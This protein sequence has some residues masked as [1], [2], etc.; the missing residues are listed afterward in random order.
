M[1]G[2]NSFELALLTL[3]VTFCVFTILGRICQCIE[4]CAEASCMKQI[5]KNNPDLKVG[6]IAKIA[7]EVNANVGK[8]N[9]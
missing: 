4:T 7:K 8:E 2:Y 3:V 5:Y 6:D 9:S 1:F